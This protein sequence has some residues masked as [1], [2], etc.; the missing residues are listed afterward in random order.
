MTNPD[1]F[2][3]NLDKLWG[4]LFSGDAARVRKLWTNFTDEECG[5]V[6]Q[7]LQRM[8]DEP[9]YQPVQ[10]ESAATAL[11]LIREIDQ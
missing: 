4:D 6:L 1:E 11:R 9:D 8:I 3:A 5:I 10:K 2:K 7:H